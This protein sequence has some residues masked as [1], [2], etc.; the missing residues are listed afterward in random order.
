MSHFQ[1]L[2]R[3]NGLAPYCDG[4]PIVNLARFTETET[5]VFVAEARILSI[6]QQMSETHHKQPA[7]FFHIMKDRII[8]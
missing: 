7:I 3:L 6:L 2:F 8:F 1:E 4:P 5:C